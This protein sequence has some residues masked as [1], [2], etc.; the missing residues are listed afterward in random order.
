MITKL[1]DDFTQQLRTQEM[2]AVAAAGR[3]EKLKASVARR[4]RLCVR[5]R[6]RALR[7]TLKQK[8]TRLVRQQQR[9]AAEQP[10]TPL[11][12]EGITEDFD[13]LTLDD[14]V[15][16]TREARLR[17]A[18]AD[19]K[20]HRATNLLHNRFRAN[21]HW[22]GKTTKAL[23]Q[24]ISNKFSDNRVRRLDPV[25]GAPPRAVHDKADI[26]ADAWQP[27]LQQP[28]AAA[29]YVD[30]VV[31]WD[32]PNDTTS[33]DQAAIAAD[34]S[35]DEVRDAL[36]ACKQ[37]KAAGPDR[38]GN[39]WYRDYEDKLVPILVA[40]FNLWYTAGHFP[41]SFVEAD[42]FCL[43]KGGGVVWRCPQ[44]QTIGVTQ[45]GL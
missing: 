20:Q 5:E 27:I 1:L 7:N 18:I 32:R 36:R 43:K 38:L 33:P 37:G 35:E 11:T 40:L 30:E 9:L 42:I 29:S 44:L 31:G 12:V 4:T 3:W 16:P 13:A 45:H 28:A 26:L 34:I 19:C 23:F 10:G 2:D 6:R 17:R 41:Q 22:T 21:T 15:G 14:T 24:R 8:L 25:P 39:G